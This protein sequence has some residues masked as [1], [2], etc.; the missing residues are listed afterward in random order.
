MGA[1]GSGRA[2]GADLLHGRCGVRT[3]E[4]A[5]IRAVTVSITDHDPIRANGCRERPRAEIRCTSCADI[6]LVSGVLGVCWRPVA[7][8]TAA[9]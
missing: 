3:P 5:P 4:Q 9:T 7:G 1:S 2:A 8:E 6:V